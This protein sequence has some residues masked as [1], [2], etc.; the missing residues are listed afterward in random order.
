[1]PVL[2]AIGIEIFV[3]QGVIM[4]YGSLRLR[5]SNRAAS[6]A[7]GFKIGIGGVIGVPRGTEEYER[8]CV[9]HGVTPYSANR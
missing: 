2:A 8:W 5:A 6:R 4:I 3:G 1:M 7:L 9:K